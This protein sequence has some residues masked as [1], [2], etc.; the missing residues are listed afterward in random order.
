MFHTV[1]SVSAPSC[2]TVN[3]KMM[4]PNIA[5]ALAVCV[6]ATCLA[7]DDGHVIVPSGQEHRIIRAVP[8]QPASVW[9]GL[10]Y[11][12][13]PAMPADP[14]ALLAASCSTAPQVRAVTENWQACGEDLHVCAPARQVRVACSAFACCTGETRGP[15]YKRGASRQKG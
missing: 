10:P 13:C 5:K 3:N 12:I 8:V 6:R 15:S 2:C 7:V 1:Q 9:S 11:I 14:S 4:P